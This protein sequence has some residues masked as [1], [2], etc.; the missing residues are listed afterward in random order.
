MCP[1]PP[2]QHLW[3]RNFGSYCWRRLDGWTVGLFFLIQDFCSCWTRWKN[4]FQPAPKRAW[5]SFVM[6]Q[7]TK[8]ICLFLSESMVQWNMGVS[9]TRIATFERSLQGESLKV[10]FLFF[11]FGSFSPNSFCKKG[12]CYFKSRGGLCWYIYIYICIYIY[13]YIYICFFFWDQDFS[14]FGWG[15]G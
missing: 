15:R 3:G 13:V 12:D 14:S 10:F 7:N 4:K 9:P 2:L 1:Y 6:F 11:P 5:N 8:I